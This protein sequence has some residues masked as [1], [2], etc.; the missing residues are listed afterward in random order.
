MNKA[1]AFHRGSF[2]RIY[3]LV[4]LECEPVLILC[5][6]PPSSFLFLRMDLTLTSLAI[7]RASNTDL[8]L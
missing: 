7:V 3:R 1:S 5:R 6:T 2:F 8:G 4:R